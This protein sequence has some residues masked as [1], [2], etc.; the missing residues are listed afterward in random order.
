MI[1]DSIV[2][3]FGFVLTIA[4]IYIVKLRFEIRDLRSDAR[5]AAVKQR[6]LIDYIDTLNKQVPAKKEKK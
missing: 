5:L 1:L 3:G 6:L 4:G 2:V